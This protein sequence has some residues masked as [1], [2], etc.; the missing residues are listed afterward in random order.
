MVVN[1]DTVIATCGV[2]TIAGAIFAY[3]NK[4]NLKPF[5]ILIENNT[6]AMNAITKVVE[7]HTTRIVKLE[8]KHKIH[9]PEED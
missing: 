3:V 1:A 6:D 7:D 4:A 2:V 8:T 5:K 9:H